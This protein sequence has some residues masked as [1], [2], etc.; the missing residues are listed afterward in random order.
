[1]VDFNFSKWIKWGHRNNLKNLKFPGVYSIA[2][3][4][5]NLENQ[6]FKWINEIIYIGMTNSQKGLK[7][8]LKQ[9]DNTIIGKTGH[10]GA[11]RVRYE[12]EDYEKLTN[13][14]YVSVQSIECDV[15]SNLPQDLRKMGNVAKL[16]YD[17][18][19]KFSECFNRL[20]KFNDKKNSPKYSREKGRKN[21]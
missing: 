11:D 14:L 1:M 8:R 17:C 12:F 7:S 3:H 15:T 21:V 18:F 5:E 4:H 13:N 6:E 19:A 10:G 16:E 9:F 2:Y 20:P